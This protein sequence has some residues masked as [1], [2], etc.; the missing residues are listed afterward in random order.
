MLRSIG[1][2]SFLAFIAFL[3]SN[4]SATAQGRSGDVVIQDKTSPPQL[5]FACD[6]QTSELKSLFTPE[7]IAD[8]RQLKVGVALSTADFTPERAQLVRTLNNAG[9]PVIA[10]LVLPPEQGYYVNASNARQTTARFEEFDRWTAINGLRW[11]A[12]GLDIE[13]TLSEFSTV[14]G[15]K[16]RVLSLILRRAF[17][18]GHVRQA[19]ESYAALI[20]EMQTRGYYVQTYQLMFLADERRSHSTVLER[21]FG[22]VD[23]RGN[24][25]VLM[26]YSSF[27]HAAGA[28]ILWEYGPDAQSIA[29]GS[30]A[31]SGDKAADAKFPPLD[32]DEFSRDLLVARHFSSGMVGVYSLDGCVR[33]GFIARLKTLDWNQEVVVPAVSV[34]KAARI[35]RVVYAVLWFSSH[36]IYFAVAFFIGIVWLL[37]W[38]VKR[39]R[40][41]SA[42]SDVPYPAS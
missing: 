18:S 19:R 30:T 4:A 2:Y 26:L 39:R 21:I 40:R 12:I 42:R 35:R 25:E 29:V 31:T 8:L 38:L 7:L 24:D 36:I 13:P 17:D 33:Q 16:W 32:W 10:W 15:S 1:R 23:V 37:S 3:V 28:G 11:Q 27:N 34:R 9:I 20:R 14:K 6:R 5:V 22:I 41:R